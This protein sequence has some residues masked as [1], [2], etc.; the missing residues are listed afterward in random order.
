MTFLF[1]QTYKIDSNQVDVYE[2]KRIGKKRHLFFSVP[3]IDMLEAFKTFNPFP[4]EL[5]NFYMEIG[6]GFLHR[7]KGQLNILLD[8]VSLVNSN[9]KLGYFKDDPYIENAF[10]HC[11]NEKQ[12]LF[13]KM[14]TGQYL[15]INREEEKDKNA[16]FYKE[17]QITSSLYDFLR[18]YNNNPDYLKEEMKEIEELSEKINKNKNTP[19]KRAN[20][21]YIG[22]H[23]LIDP[24]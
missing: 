2:A 15:S 3:E 16:I 10:K 11:N 12:L 13:F 5:K 8:P 1:L 24:Y 17:K 20:V 6:F 18:Y 19:T 7:K 23:R 4:T 9:L 14:H 21:K 22:G